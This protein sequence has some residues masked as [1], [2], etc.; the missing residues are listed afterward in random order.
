VLVVTTIYALFLLNGIYTD[1]FSTTGGFGQ[2]DPLVS[3][4]SNSQDWNAYAYV[5]NDPVNLVDP[6]GECPVAAL[7]SL[8]G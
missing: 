3:D 4:K 8:Q 1:G 7:H 2:V 5:R 6:T